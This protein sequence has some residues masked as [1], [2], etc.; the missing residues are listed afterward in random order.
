MFIILFFIFYIYTFPTKNIAFS[1]ILQIVMRSKTR[2]VRIT[3]VLF[4][5]ESFCKYQTRTNINYHNTTTS[6]VRDRILSVTKHG[7]RC[8]H[9]VL[10]VLAPRWTVSSTT[11]GFFGESIA[12]GTRPC[13][14]L[15][16]NVRCTLW[17]EKNRKL[18]PIRFVYE[19]RFWTLHPTDNVF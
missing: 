1:H 15:R 3:V 16:A 14:G 7:L 19:F 10:V 5:V 11:R 18:R 8:L 13:S 6:A 17:N 12:F 4:I 2:I 9:R